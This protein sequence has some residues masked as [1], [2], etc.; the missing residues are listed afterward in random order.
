MDQR[1][2]IRSGGRRAFQLLVERVIVVYRALIVE[3]RRV[4]VAAT[5][6][7]AAEVIAGMLKLI[8]IRVDGY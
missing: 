2:L 1:A 8:E 3:A 6:A 4:L 7:V 5:V